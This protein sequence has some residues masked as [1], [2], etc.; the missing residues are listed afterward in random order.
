MQDASWFPGLVWY[1]YVF[2]SS[3]RGLRVRHQ[4]LW[5]YNLGRDVAHPSLPDVP[6]RLVDCADIATVWS[7][8]IGDLASRESL[9]VD[10]VFVSCGEFGTV[11]S[12]IAVIILY[13]RQYTVGEVISVT[14][15]TTVESK[16][17]TL[18]LNHL[19]HLLVRALSVGVA[20]VIQ[21]DCTEL[22]IS[23]CSGGSDKAQDVAFSRSISSLDLN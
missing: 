16:C 20:H 21:Q 3:I 22:L 2:L 4:S 7:T 9:A 14:D 13:T 17:D 15:I 1:G 18:L 19:Q 8:I 6:I 10:R 11:L 23:A 5:T 12:T